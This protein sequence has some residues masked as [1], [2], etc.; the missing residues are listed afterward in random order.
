MVNW[1]RLVKKVPHRIQIKKN[2]FYEVVYIDDFA[3]G[4]TMGEARF[5]ER[6]IV[7]KRGLSPK[8]TIVTFLHELTHVASYEYGIDLTENQVLATE[9][10]YYYVLKPG[11]IFNED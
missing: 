4:K 1:K 5:N 2:V 3:D 8:N 10:F 9:G 7:I 11:N 6:Q